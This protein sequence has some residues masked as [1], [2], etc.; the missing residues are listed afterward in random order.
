MQDAISSWSPLLFVIRIWDI[1]GFWHKF[2]VDNVST[3]ACL[4][5]LTT[6]VEQKRPVWWTLHVRFQLLVYFVLKICHVCICKCLQDFGDCCAHGPCSSW[7]STE[8]SSRSESML[9]TSMKAQIAQI[10]PIC[11]SFPLNPQVNN[12]VFS[13]LLFVFHRELRVLSR[14][15]LFLFT[16]HQHQSLDA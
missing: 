5:N 8:F 15:V 11:V 4:L 1:W 2:L 7:D 10:I 14:G 13:V 16:W 3:S 12:R 6:S 9:T